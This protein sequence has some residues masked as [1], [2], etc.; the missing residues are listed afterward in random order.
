MGVF[1]RDNNRVPIDN[2]FYATKSITFDGGTA[3]D[4]GD[5][6]GTGNPA[7]LFTV[8]GEVLVRVYGVCT[9][10]LAGALATL[11]IGTT[12]ST[13]GLI[14][15]TTATDIDASEIWHDASPDTDIELFTV[16]T[17]KI[18]ANGADIIQ[19]VGTADITSGVIVYHCLW[20]PISLTGN[21][22]AA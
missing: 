6:S 1:K 3:N 18:V 14:A 22:V 7:T 9:T 13:A 4:P 12:K 20:L 2:Y 5:E 21:V 11:E 17:E 19:T 15:Q 16:A 10:L 8:T